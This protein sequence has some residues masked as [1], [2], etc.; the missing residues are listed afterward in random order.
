MD[1][2]FLRVS[3]VES[4]QARS[5]GRTP[6][7]LIKDQLNAIEDKFSIS[8]DSKNIIQEE[9]SAYDLEKLNKREGFLELLEILCCA[10]STTIKDV[11]LKTVN[12]NTR[13]NLY[14]WDYD[15]FMR[16]IE[17]SVIFQAISDIFD[18]T[19]YSYKDGKTLKR[20]DETP[21]EKVA[22]YMLIS[23]RA[24]AAEQYSYTISENIKKT[25]L[26]EDQAK[27]ILVTHSTKGNV[28]GRKFVN[29]AG[30]KVTLSP[31]E[32][33]EIRKYIKK[34]IKYFDRKKRKGYGPRIKEE[35]ANKFNIKISDAYITERRKDIYV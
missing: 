14:V 16:N 24:F 6:K 17:R 15:R 33:T 7:Q 11:F 10:S 28:W 9:G 31:E 22:R 27:K 8:F 5:E 4:Q 34:R 12:R 23:V 19:I 35:I 32:A 13:I 29:L 20:A 30:L 26:I 18:I 3:K 25:V 2:C 1:L 21:S